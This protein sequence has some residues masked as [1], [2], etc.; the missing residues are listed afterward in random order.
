V[1]PI[2]DSLLGI[3][4]VRLHAIEWRIANIGFLSGALTIPLVGFVMASVAAHL[5]G[6]RK[7]QRILA[8][9]YALLGLL[10]LMSLAL[11]T[12]DVLQYRPQVRPEL[13][14]TYELVGIKAM[15][16]Q[17]ILALVL[18]ALGVASLQHSRASARR[19]GRKR[20][21][22]SPQTPVFT[23]TAKS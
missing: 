13:R 8:T 21:E 7:T 6:H 14:R 3:I 10:V 9:F 15:L 16:A 23:A 17:G 2:A 11:F 1:L 12:F 4:P 20:Q 5:L 19:E 22:Q 18:L